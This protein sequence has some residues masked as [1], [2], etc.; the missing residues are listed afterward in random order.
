MYNFGAL[1]LAVYLCIGGM[2][3]QCLHPCPGWHV[4]ACSC[5]NQGDNVLASR[6]LFCRGVGPWLACWL[7]EPVLDP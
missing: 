7:Q 4:S 1:Q 2:S 5:Y 6:C 3:G